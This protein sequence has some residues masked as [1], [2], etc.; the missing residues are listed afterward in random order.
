MSCQGKVFPR[1]MLSA[2]ENGIFIIPV[3]THDLH[4]QPETFSIENSAV[5]MNTSGIITHLLTPKTDFFILFQLRN[6][7][8]FDNL[9]CTELTWELHPSRTPLHTMTPLRMPGDSYSATIFISVILN[10]LTKVYRKQP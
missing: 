3:T 8:F 7:L 6:T 4:C 9:S 10:P 2:E 1:I 5:S